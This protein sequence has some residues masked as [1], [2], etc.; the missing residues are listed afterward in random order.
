MQDA[1]DGFVKSASSSKDP[2]IVA[3]SHIYLG[4][5]F[6]LQD[7]REAAIEQYKAA[8]SA[9]DNSPDTHSAAERGLQSPYEPPRD[10]AAAE[11]AIR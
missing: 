8:L 7:D 3:W 5:I 2:R 10:F 1:K 4:R 6:D 11:I 9:G